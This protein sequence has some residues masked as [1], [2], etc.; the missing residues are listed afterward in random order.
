M[1]DQFLRW[2][3][4]RSTRD[5]FARQAEFFS[6]RGI[7][8]EHPN[9]RCGIILDVDGNHVQLETAKIAR[10]ID[11]KI[12]P[13]NVEFWLSADHDLACR[14]SWIPLGM[15]VQ[16]YYLDNLT[17]TESQIVESLLIDYI[18]QE[19]SGTFGYVL[20]RD[21]RT[22][23]YDWDLFYDGLSMG[24]YRRFETYPDVLA[25][26]GSVGRIREAI[27]IPDSAEVD[28]FGDALVEVKRGPN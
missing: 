16:M 24:E 1:A 5:D 12:A 17:R 18:H 11:L 25:V 19:S 22:A 23:E 28:R 9:F 3:R 26:S 14:F 13:V 21:G 15:E 4:A 7:S 20:D 27:N 6:R 2:Y 10:L 8:L